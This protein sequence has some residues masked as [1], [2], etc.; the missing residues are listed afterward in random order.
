MNEVKELIVD[1]M[2]SHKVWEFLMGQAKANEVKAKGK[3]R[4]GKGKKG[5][6]C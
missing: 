1:I 4:K 5:K 3:P 2:I 6:G